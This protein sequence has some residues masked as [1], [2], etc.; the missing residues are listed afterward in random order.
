MSP[1][2]TNCIASKMRTE[3]SRTIDR[4]IK[5]EKRFLRVIYSLMSKAAERSSH[6]KMTSDAVRGTW[7]DRY[8]SLALS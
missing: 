2:Y 5:S 7:K 3:Q 1:Q 6:M 8:K 4:S